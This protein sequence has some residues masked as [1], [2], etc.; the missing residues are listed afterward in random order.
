MVHS[1]LHHCYSPHRSLLE[2]YRVAKRGLLAV[3]GRD[4]L[5]MRCAAKLL[6]GVDYEITA[7]LSEAE[8]CGVA[9]TSVPNYVYRW[10]EREIVKTIS[11]N[12]PQARHLYRFFHRFD[13]PFQILKECASRPKVFAAKL[14]SPLVRLLTLVIPG[15]GNRFAFYVGKPSYPQDLHPWMTIKDGEFVLDKRWT[16]RHMH[17]QAGQT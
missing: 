6:W 14:L 15:Q 17:S 5:L 10:T 3:E 13:I 11:S 16:D 1:G 4:S 12:A 9:G 7:V 2:M 8:P